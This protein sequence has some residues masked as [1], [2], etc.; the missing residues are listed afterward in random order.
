VRKAFVASDVDGI[1][2]VTEGAGVLVQMVT[3]RL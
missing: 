3:Q 2:E 1:H